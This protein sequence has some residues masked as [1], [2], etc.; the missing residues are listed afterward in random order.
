MPRLSFHKP[1]RSTLVFCVNS[2][3]IRLLHSSLSTRVS[4]LVSLDCWDSSRSS[5][6]QVNPCNWKIYNVLLYQSQYYKPILKETKKN[7]WKAQSKNR[8]LSAQPQNFLEKVIQIG[9]YR[10]TVVILSY[11]EVLISMN[12]LKLKTRYAS[13]DHPQQWDR[14]ISYYKLQWRSGANKFQ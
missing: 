4:L 11:L 3:W 6:P 12:A 9:H 7:L 2:M 5:I 13:Q 10:F 1:S 14:E 8:K